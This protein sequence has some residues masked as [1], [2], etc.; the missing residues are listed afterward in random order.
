MSG[1]GTMP[2]LSSDLERTVRR[3]VCHGLRMASGC[4]PHMRRTKVPDILRRT[5]DVVWKEFEQN[6]GSLPDYPASRSWSSDTSGKIGGLRSSGV[7]ADI[8][9]VDSGLSCSSR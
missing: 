8:D 2:V 9:D 6:G 1:F 3:L 7:D 4:R 5:A